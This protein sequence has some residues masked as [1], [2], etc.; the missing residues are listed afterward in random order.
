[1]RKNK[2]F[3]FLSII[4]LIFIFG[5]AVTCNLCGTPIEIGETEDTSVE[6]TEEDKT[7]SSQPSQSE[8]S[9]QQ[10]SEQTQ[11][12]DEATEP[13]SEEAVELETEGEPDPETADV[14]PP[15]DE[16]ESEDITNH[17]PEIISVLVIDRGAHVTADYLYTD[18]EYEIRV[19]FT[20]LDAFD[21]DTFHYIWT[22]GWG[23]EDYGNITEPNA[24]STTWITPSNPVDE[25]WLVA[26]VVDASDAY[27]EAGRQFR[28]VVGSGI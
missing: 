27:D 1:M 12:T 11:Q 21:G 28:I 4:A 6:L 3:I 24:Q 26:R 15:E 16:S 8:Q 23:H 7:D 22:L 9:Q 2:V 20:D 25:V 19:E 14:I 5:I 10:S 13:E 17:P 18:V